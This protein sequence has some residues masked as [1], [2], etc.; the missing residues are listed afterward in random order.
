MDIWC[1]EGKKKLFYFAKG[2]LIFRLFRI[3]AR[4]SKYDFWNLGKFWD[5]NR[6]PKKIWAKKNRRKKSENFLVENFLGPKN[7]DFWSKKCS[8]KKSMKIQNFEISIFS[9]IFRNFKILNFHLLFQR[10]MFR[11]K[12]RKLLVQIFFSTKSFLIFS[13]KK[14]SQFF[15]GYLFRSKIFPRFQ[16]SHLENCAMRPGIQVPVISVMGQKVTFF[17]TN[18]PG[19]IPSLADPLYNISSI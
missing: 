17:S 6:W 1:L 11:S 19:E 8:L 18:L 3:I 7:F 9:K 2:F 12:N 5:R 15:L 13:T 16:K 14:I 4:C 10:K